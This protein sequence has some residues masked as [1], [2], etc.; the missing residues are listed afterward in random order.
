MRGLS[1]AYH[2]TRV[3]ADP[4]GTRLTCRDLRTRNFNTRFGEIELTLDAGGSV[5]EMEF[6][7]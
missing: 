3:E 7:V 4:G 5:R 6:H 2:V 1:P